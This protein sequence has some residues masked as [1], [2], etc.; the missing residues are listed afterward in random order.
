MIEEEN[1]SQAWCQFALKTIELDESSNKFIGYH[2]LIAIYRMHLTSS[3]FPNLNFKQ[4]QKT[5]PDNHKCKKITLDGE[6]SSKELM[7]ALLEL[8]DKLKKFD[9]INEIFFSNLKFDTSVDFSNFIFPVNVSFEGTKFSEIAYFRDAVFLANTNFR[10]A[11]F[12]VISSFYETQFFGEADF[13]R[14]KFCEYTNFYGAK[15]SDEAIFTGTHFFQEAFLAPRFDKV[16]FL[17]RALFTYAQFHGRALFK[18]TAFSKDAIF[19]GAKFTYQVD[20]E[21]AVFS[22]NAIFT[23]AEFPSEIKFDG[24]QFSS[25]T[26]F[27]DTKFYDKVSFRDAKFLSYTTFKESTFKF[28]AP[29]FYG[30]EINDEIFWTDIKLPKFEKANDET[31]EKYKKRIKDNENA[32]E[33][34]STKLGNQKKY[35]DEH[36]FFRQELSCQQKLAESYT[37]RFAFWLYELFSDYG[38]RI[39]RAFWCWAGHIALGALVIAFIAMCGG[40]RYHESLPCAIYVSFAN[41]NPYVFF[42]FES[43]SLTACYTELEP[44]APIS[45]A[46][47]K[48]IQTAFGIALL[49][50]L[51]ITLRTRFRLK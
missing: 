32:Y 34:L 45:F 30:A 43:S 26:F 40:M 18:E 19:K 10:R 27:D 11:V 50:L 33:N 9:T 25:L 14:A 28:Y 4:I 8:N 2:W 13:D 36:F 38:Y 51:I 47:V 46:I 17:G 49:S 39:G 20:F 22:E 16:V 15:F 35:R 48:V 31:E 1:I 23:N 6:I 24:T 21:K 41:A 5:L 29:K 3:K 12:S 42:G 44:L 37:S 7:N